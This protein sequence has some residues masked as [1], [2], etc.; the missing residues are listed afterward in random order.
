MRIDYADSADST[1]GAVSQRPPTHPPPPRARYLRLPVF[2]PI[3]VENVNVDPTPG[4]LVHSIEPPIELHRWADMARPRPVPPETRLEWW[5][6]G[7]HAVYPAAPPAAPPKRNRPRMVQ[8]AK[9]QGG[10]RE[11]GS[12]FIGACSPHSCKTHYSTSLDKYRVSAAVPRRRHVHSFERILLARPRMVGM[13][14]VEDRLTS[15]WFMR[16]IY[17]AFKAVPGRPAAPSPSSPD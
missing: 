15:Y 10:V 5:T 9:K 1:S 12:T 17:S 8:H 16:A 11:A 7:D 14:Y 4:V 2:K 13:A 6:Y 3:R